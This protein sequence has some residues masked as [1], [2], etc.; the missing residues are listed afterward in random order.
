MEE[1]E[2]PQSPDDDEEATRKPTAVERRLEQ[3]VKQLEEARSASILAQAAAEAIC[4][5]KDAELLRMH[6]KIGEAEQRGQNAAKEVEEVVM[7]RVA[8]AALRADDLER[9]LKNARFVSE[10][11]ER[12][13]AEAVVGRDAAE[14][15]AADANRDARRL[16]RHV[17]ALREKQTR[18]ELRRVERRRVE[19]INAA[20][21][22]ARDLEGDPELALP[23]GAT[24]RKKLAQTRAKLQ[25]LLRDR[26]TAA[27]MADRLD[28]QARLDDALRTAAATGRADHVHVLAARG[29]RADQPDA[30]GA[31]ALD[32][33]CG[34]GHADACR[35]C[36]EA[37]ADAL[38][39]ALG[40]GGL[41]TTG[42]GRVIGGDAPPLAAENPY[43]KPTSKPR[44]SKTQKGITQNE[45]AACAASRP[46]VIAAARGHVEVMRVL[47]DHVGEGPPLARLL[48]AADAQGRTAL[49]ACALHGA[50]RAAKML[51]DAGADVDAVDGTGATPLHVAATG[52]CGDDDK[53]CEI[54]ALLSS[55][56]ANQAARNRSGE[57]PVDTAHQRGNVALIKAL[58]GAWEDFERLSLTT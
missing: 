39:D 42:R 25:E 32:Y 40:L 16:A 17:G 44:R 43:L 26:D 37:G 31:T 29:G 3:R 53:A 19:L 38:G 13:A 57:R 22:V 55:R 8:A 9:R 47:M 4:K 36:L 5:A 11:S 1:D 46:L 49:H 50:T 6:A 14:R 51:V 28:K 18:E 34:A 20:E 48:A 41:F 24:K 15:E 12:L 21:T 58:N 10:A 7:R 56:H 2:R 54:V 30:H 52:D 45:A 35:A 33:A 23:I 27:K